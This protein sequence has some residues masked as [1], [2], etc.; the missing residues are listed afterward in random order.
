[1]RCFDN[2]LIFMKTDAQ[3]Q[4]DVMEEMKWDPATSSIASGIGVTAREGIVTLSGQVDSFF[5]KRAVEAAAQRVKGVSFVAMD[6][7]IRIGSGLKK[8]DSDIAKSIKDSLKHLSIV[9]ME[10][11]DV[12]VD[13]GYVVLTGTMKWN[14]QRQVAEEYVRNV[15]GVRGVNNLVELSDEPCNPKTITENINAAFHRHATLDAAGIHVEIKG[16]KALLT[17]KVRSWIEKKDAENVAWSSP[18]IMAVENRIT[19]ANSYVG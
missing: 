7:E 5:Q 4:Q 11:I 12:K 2:K 1:M 6:I 19:V 13:D 8:S 9:D 16:N 14:Y 18:G 10:D 17:G 3:L 15:S